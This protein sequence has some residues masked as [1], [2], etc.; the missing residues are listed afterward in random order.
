[1]QIYKKYYKQLRRR[2]CFRFEIKTFP[3]KQIKHDFKTTTNYI[4]YKNILILSL[5]VVKV[6]SFELTE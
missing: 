1:M 2:M 4:I 5:T 3:Q 6:R